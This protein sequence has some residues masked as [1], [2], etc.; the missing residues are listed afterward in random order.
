MNSTGEA[1]GLIQGRAK[2][3]LILLES[4]NCQ[5]Y[6]WL[7]FKSS[8]LYKQDTAFLQPKFVTQETNSEAYRS[9]PE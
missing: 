3:G 9:S 5:C 2:Q 1:D 6:S 8:V 7:T 4:R